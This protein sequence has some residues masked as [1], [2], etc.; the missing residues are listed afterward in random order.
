M[1][2]PTEQKADAHRLDAQLLSDLWVFRAAGRFGSI[3]AAARHLGVTQ[4][5]VSQRVLRLEARLETP[6]F[7]RNK[8][9][10]V[11][12]DAGTLLMDSM[13]NVAN[14]LN[15]SISRIYKQ[16]RGAIVLSCVPSLAT[17]WLVAHLESFYREHPGIEIF[18]RSEFVVWTAER[19]VDEGVD[20]VIDYT[21]ATPDGMHELAAVRELLFPVCSR[22]Y[23]DRLQSSEPPPIV[24][25][26][27]DVP[28][29]GEAPNLEWSDWRRDIGTTWPN[30]PVTDRHFNLSILAYHAALCDQ[31]IA[32][33][34]AAI[35]QRLVQRGELVLATPYAPIP[36]PSYRV[37]T[38][39]PGDARSPARQFAAWWTRT[40]TETQAQMLTLITPTE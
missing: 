22:A 17:E 35:V 23:F 10:I 1:A 4:G 25:L 40:M 21:G 3:T 20:L 15:H 37:M 11:L 27:D 34:R 30:A 31:G 26:H 5:A 14:E 33:G 9:R 38:H 2:F 39:R 13:T 8:S 28:C 18:L 29:A 16:Q 6:L 7:I 12:T 36:G 24:L 32:M 19:L